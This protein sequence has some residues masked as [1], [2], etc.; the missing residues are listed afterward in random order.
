MES[1]I[2]ENWFARLKAV[3]LAKDIEGVRSLLSES[4]RYYESPFDDPLMSWEAV[5]KEW[6]AVSDQNIVRLDIETL[7][8]KGAEGIAT[9]TLVLKDENEVEHTSCGA[10]YV[11]LD[12]MG[13]AVE[14]RQWWMNQ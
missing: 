2:V 12:G 5:R 11:R 14:F 1:P 7:L 9:Y 4:F 8:I 13:K 3:W 6:C 10:Y